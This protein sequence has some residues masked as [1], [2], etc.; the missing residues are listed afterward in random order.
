MTQTI[1]LSA[2]SP[3]LD[4]KNTVLWQEAHTFLRVVFPLN[5][6]SDRATY[7]TQFGLLQ[8]PTHFNT[9]YDLAQFEVPAQRWADLSE[10]DFGVALLNDSKYGYAC[11]GSELSLSLLR[12]PKDPDPLADIGDHHFAYALL[13]HALTPS[14]AL[15]GGRQP[16]STNHLL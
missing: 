9:S 6:R 5:L 2:V 1:S 8:R 7:E 12:S 10:P 4:F 3:R 14:S 15:S 13:P 11:Y 16:L